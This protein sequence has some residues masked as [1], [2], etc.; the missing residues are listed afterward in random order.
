MNQE[1]STS[2]G[3]SDESLPTGAEA[4]VVVAGSGPAGIAASLAAAQ[5]LRVVLVERFPFL[6]SM[7]TQIRSRPG[8]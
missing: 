8:R 1:G 5:G 7:S 3:A 6:G 2:L 4:D